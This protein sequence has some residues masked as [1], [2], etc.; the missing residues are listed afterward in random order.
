MSRLFN[1]EHS[2]KEEYLYDELK[3]L[4]VEPNRKTELN[5]EELDDLAKNL[6]QSMFEDYKLA[7]SAKGDKFEEEARSTVNI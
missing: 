7:Y 4:G 5:E 2:D 3:S 6:K 1:N